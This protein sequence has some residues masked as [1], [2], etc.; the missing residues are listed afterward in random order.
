[1]RVTHSSHAA[2]NMSGR[3]V[4]FGEVQQTLDS[5]DRIQPS[6]RDRDLYIAQ[7]AGRDITVVLTREALPT[8]VT[9]F[10]D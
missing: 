7:I 3:R 10:V 8:V 1:M 4:S 2:E 9:V 6:Y 5:R